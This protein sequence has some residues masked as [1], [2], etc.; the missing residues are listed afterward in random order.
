[1][2]SG[3][4]Q[5]GFISRD[6]VG[7]LGDGFGA[8]LAESGLGA[9]AWPHSLVCGLTGRLQH[10]R[11]QG[12]SSFS[13]VA[14]VSCMAGSAAKADTFQIPSTF[15]AS[16]GIPLGNAPLARA[17]HRVRYRLKGE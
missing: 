7:W 13:P 11:W 1:M 2:H 15:R 6:F 9:P 5:S 14:L 8:G 4:K 16:A 3:L 17:N 10:P 12:L